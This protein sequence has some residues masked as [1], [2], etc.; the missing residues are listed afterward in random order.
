MSASFVCRGDNGHRQVC[1]SP[2][3]GSFASGAISNLYY[4]SA[5]RGAH[6]I[7]FNGLIEMVGG[8]GN[9]LFKEF[10]LRGYTSHVPDYE[11]GKP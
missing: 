9:N 3:L 5:S 10:F 1:Y 7:V 11:N 4:P 2:V 8:I 6:L